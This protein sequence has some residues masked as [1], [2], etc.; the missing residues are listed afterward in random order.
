MDSQDEDSY[1]VGDRVD[2]DNDGIEE[3]ILN[4][5]NGGMY[6]DVCKGYEE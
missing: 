6:L 1:S 4:G 5:P 3:L 2:L